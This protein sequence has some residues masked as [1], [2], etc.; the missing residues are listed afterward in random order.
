MDRCLVT[1]VSM[2]LYIQVNIYSLYTYLK[3]LNNEN[4]AVD[5][6]QETI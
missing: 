4:A 2:S 1:T 3:Q 6:F 5:M